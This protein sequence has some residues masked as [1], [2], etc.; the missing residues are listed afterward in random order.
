MN[1]YPPKKAAIRCVA[2]YSVSRTDFGTDAELLQTQFPIY[3]EALDTRVIAAHD[4]HTNPYTSEFTE[5]YLKP[6]GISSTLDAPIRWEGAMIGV[7][8]CEHTGPARNWTAEWVAI[9]NLP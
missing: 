8:C 7:V 9:G 2:S 5:T 6:L 3:F 1:V 4:T